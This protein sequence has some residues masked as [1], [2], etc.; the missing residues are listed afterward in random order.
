M[1]NQFYLPKSTLPSVMNFD[2]VRSDGH[3]LSFAA[4]DNLGI[5]KDEYTRTY[6]TH[7]DDK[8]TPVSHNYAITPE[9]YL[10]ALAAFLGYTLIPPSEFNTNPT[11]DELIAVIMA[12]ADADGKLRQNFIQ[13]VK[14]VREYTGWGLREAKLVTDPYRTHDHLCK[15]M[16]CRPY[17]ASRW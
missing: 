15:C 6:I 3:I 14:A 7:F 5:A 1:A 2:I 16:G 8:D 11:Q 9:D 10:D 12:H 4:D 13:A 17:Q